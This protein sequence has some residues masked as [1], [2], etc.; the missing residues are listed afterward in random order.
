MSTKIHVKN[1]RQNDVGITAA[2]AMCAGAK[3]TPTINV[4]N[5]V[6]MTLGITSAQHV[7]L[8]ETEDSSKF[9]SKI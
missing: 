9:S 4:K 6:K 2:H 5:N 8:Y 3:Q 7:D 1:Q